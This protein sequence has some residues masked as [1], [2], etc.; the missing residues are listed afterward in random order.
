MAR[1]ASKE[2]STRYDVVTDH[3]T[4]ERVN[5]TMSVVNNLSENFQRF[6]ENYQYDYEQQ[7]EFRDTQRNFNEVT[8]YQ[9]SNITYNFQ[10][11]YEFLTILYVLL[12]SWPMRLFNYFAKIYFIQY[13][14][15]TEGIQYRIRFLR[16]MPDSE[17]KDLIEANEKI[18]QF[19]KQLGLRKK[20]IKP[21]VD[22][23]F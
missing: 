11:I 16:G 6:M 8:K 20:D 2:E 9:M 7:R 17:Y 13:V 21:F 22:F 4:I 14:Y 15:T 19:I 3:E 23:R 1:F 5:E 12:Y 18:Q 10:T